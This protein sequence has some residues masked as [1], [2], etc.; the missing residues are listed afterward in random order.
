MGSALRFAIPVLILLRSALFA[1]VTEAN[2]KSSY[3]ITSDGAFIVDAA[4][5]LRAVFDRNGEAC[6]LALYGHLSED[7]V[8]RVFDVLVPVKTRGGKTQDLIQ[9]AGICQRYLAYENV[10]L[11]TWAVGKQTAEPAAII[12]FSHPDCKAAIAEVN[13]IVVHTKRNAQSPAPNK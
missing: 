12:T 8:V 7:Q 3:P 5:K 1:Q 10:A 2:L 11:G 9:C 6:T 4:A 13:K